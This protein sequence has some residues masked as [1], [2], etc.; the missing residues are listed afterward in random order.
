MGR[1]GDRETRGQGDGEKG[2][3]GKKEVKILVSLP[4]VITIL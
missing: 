2:R 3:R 1:V 4:C